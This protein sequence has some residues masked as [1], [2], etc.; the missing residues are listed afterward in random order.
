MQ[1][2]SSAISKKKMSP[3]ILATLTSSAV[4]ASATAWYCMF[5]PR[6]VVNLERPKGTSL[7]EFLASLE[8]VDDVT[9]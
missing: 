8:P 1:N 2:I 6:A 3:E 5:V 4:I 9:L 7:G